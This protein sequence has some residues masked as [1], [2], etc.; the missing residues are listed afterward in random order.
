MGDVELVLVGPVFRGDWERVGEV[1]G[2]A[3][4]L[5]EAEAEREAVVDRDERRTVVR[6]RRTGVMRG[7]S[8]AGTVYDSDSDV[9]NERDN[10]NVNANNAGSR[11]RTHTHT[12][13]PHPH[14]L[15]LPTSL[16]LHLTHLRLTEP[17][18]LPLSGSGSGAR[19]MY[20]EAAAQILRMPRLTHVA[21]PVREPVWEGVGVGRFG[22]SGGGG[23][24]GSRIS[25][26]GEAEGGEWL[27]EVDGLLGVEEEE[28][29]EENDASDSESSIDSGSDS[30]VS[31]PLIPTLTRTTTTAHLIRR[32]RPRPT[33]TRAQLHQLVL[34]LDFR[35]WANKR[36]CGPNSLREWVERG[37]RRDE[38]V[39]VVGVGLGK[40]AWGGDDNDNGEGEESIWEYA[41]TV[42]RGCCEVG[43]A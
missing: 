10:A 22:L 26:G 24:G 38:R 20:S 37:R 6:A 18:P 17:L 42:R 32:R 36:A 5:E 11:T 16:L 23:G 43:R 34:I 8:S 31:S 33:Q 40:G 7:G 12:H 3:G 41:W 1:V 28:E 9:L 4:A 35:T 15:L 25:G 21:V 19:Y 13:T 30:P 39:F 14:P 2:L 29:V 27:R